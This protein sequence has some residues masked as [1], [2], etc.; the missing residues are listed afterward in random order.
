M[1]R[2]RPINVS[3]SVS[4]RTQNRTSRSR[5]RSREMWKGLDLG[6]VS[7]CKWNVSVSSRSRTSTSRLHPC[8]YV[9]RAP[10]FLFFEGSPNVFSES[11]CF[12]RDWVLYRLWVLSQ[13]VRRARWNWFHGYCSQ[14]CIEKIPENAF[15]CALKWC[16]PLWIRFRCL[17]Q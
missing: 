16:R 12:S 10:E 7:N 1:S 13:S 9:P 14:F 5:S 4:S 8:G 3:V 15:E 2:S 17:K 11:A 6:L